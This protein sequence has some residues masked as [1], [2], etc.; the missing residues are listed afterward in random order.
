MMSASS[1][2]TR[3]SSHSLAN[4]RAEAKNLSALA[5]DQCLALGTDCRFGRGFCYACRRH[6]QRCHSDNC[7]VE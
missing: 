1:S 3:T 4:S 6:L 7:R 2:K 5:A